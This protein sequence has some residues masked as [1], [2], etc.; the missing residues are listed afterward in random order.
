MIR[1]GAEALQV[2]RMRWKGLALRWDGGDLPALRWLDEA[3][4]SPDIH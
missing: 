1:E 2:F 4:F 3:I